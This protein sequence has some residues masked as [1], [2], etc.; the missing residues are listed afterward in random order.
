ME[1]TCI[2]QLTLISRISRI[3]QY[4]HIY[5]NLPCKETPSYARNGGRF[6]TT[7]KTPKPS[8][9]K[10]RIIHPSSGTL[11]LWEVLTWLSEGIW[12]ASHRCSLLGLLFLCCAGIVL[13]T[14]G[15]CGLL[16]I[17]F[18]VSSIRFLSLYFSLVNLDAHFKMF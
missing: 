2:P 12:P 17:L 1:I 16:V 9:I 18:S 11:G 10:V 5:D 3:P 4:T 8:Q 14:W 13:R 6:Y 7:I 15:P